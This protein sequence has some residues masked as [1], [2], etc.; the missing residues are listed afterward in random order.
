MLLNKSDL[1]H[2]KPMSASFGYG[3]SGLGNLYRIVS[4]EAADAAMAAAYDGGIRYYDTSPFYGLGL[5]EL[6]LG[7]FLRNR[8]R[9]EFI[10]STK[11]GRYMVPPRGEVVDKRGWAGA[12]NMKPVFDYSY[13][14][15][16]RSVEQSCIRLG[17]EQIDIL[18]L[19]D[20]DRFTHGARFP[21]VFAEA[22]KGAYLA[23][24]E[25]RRT[26]FV[27]LI[28]VG[29][30][31]QDVA[32]DFIRSGDFDCV[33]LAGRYTLLDQGSLDDF[34]PLAVSR[35]VQ[36]IGAGIFNSGI[37]AQ[38]PP[39]R[40][41]KFDYADA[42]PEIIAKANRIADVCARHG[43]LPQAA[44]TQFPLGHP[45]VTSV[46]LG[47]SKADHVAH[48]LEWVAADIP[49][50]LWDELKQEKLLRDDAPVPST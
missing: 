20:A 3:A 2:C 44:A 11:V 49:A 27:K 37:L 9:S 8:P 19:H 39:Y 15:V 28:G 12:L 21:E 24:D 33:M 32:A 38:T 42:G 48:S 29:V 1:P 35:N 26:G 31:E 10:L 18:Y 46:V 34:L 22:M 40:Q 36:V 13:D 25:L 50:A 47:L 30:N 41:A 4:Y 43:V 6:R 7:R 5:S 45:A 17:F 23:L 16:M 14:G